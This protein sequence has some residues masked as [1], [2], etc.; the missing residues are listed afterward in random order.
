V[1]ERYGECLTD[2]REWEDDFGREDDSECLEVTV[3]VGGGKTGELE[4]G[5]RNL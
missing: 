1:E 4:E 5:G 2:G 3:A